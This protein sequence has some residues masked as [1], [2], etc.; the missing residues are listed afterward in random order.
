[1]SR[2]ELTPKILAAKAKKG[3]KWADIAQRV[4]KSKEWTAAALMGQMSLKKEQAEAAAAALGLNL[5][6]DDM[7]ALMAVPYRGSLGQTVPTDALVYR[8][9]E[10]MQVYG[11]TMKSLIEEEFGDGI[12]SAID[13]KMS[14]D[15]EPDPA[16]DRVVVTFNGKFLPYKTF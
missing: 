5:S 6:E 4:G 10:I 3:I 7:L 15:R 11:M 1:M 12:M 16:G 2:E 14:I 8:F 13:F 9:Y